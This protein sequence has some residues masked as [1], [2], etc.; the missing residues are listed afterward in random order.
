MLT[1]GYS[2]SDPSRSKCRR[3]YNFHYYCCTFI[4]LCIY[5]LFLQYHSLSYV[6][7][8]PDIHCAV[9]AWPIQ[10][11]A[12]FGSSQGGGLS[13][14]SKAHMWQYS[15]SAGTAT[16]VCSSVW[17]TLGGPSYSFTGELSLKCK[18]FV[19]HSCLSEANCW[20]IYSVGWKG[21]NGPIVRLCC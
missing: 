17:E 18:N 12:K 19:M 2:R 8:G 15:D 5:K 3:N 14:K 20:K 10:F 7:D 6:S 11:S 1:V 21:S 16:K 13:T 4:C 9:L